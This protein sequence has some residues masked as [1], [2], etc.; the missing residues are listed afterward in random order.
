[1]RLLYIEHDLYTTSELVSTL[2]ISTIS[3]VWDWQTD[4][5]TYIKF[6][7]ILEVLIEGLDNIMNEFQHGQL[8]DVIVNVHANDEVK[9]CIS[10][11]DDFKLSVLEE[12]T[13]T[14]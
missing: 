5:D 7:N 1:M 6:A 8:V 4:Q 12:G 10:S 14:K 9:W 2:D 3:Q 11:V 13:L